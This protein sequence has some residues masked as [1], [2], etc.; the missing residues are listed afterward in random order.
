MVVLHVLPSC[1]CH[2][3]HLTHKC[4][5]PRPSSRARDRLLGTRKKKQNN[6][7]DDDDTFSVKP[8][9]AESAPE[10]RARARCVVRPRTLLYLF[11]PVHAE[12]EHKTRSRAHTNER[13]AA[14]A[15]QTKKKKHRTHARTHAAL[16]GAR[17][18]VCVPEK[19]R[20]CVLE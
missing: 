14:A 2:H 10:S 11:V 3:T 17:V 1:I 7:R 20:A 5:K 19:L 15:Q 8:R 4:G 6:K 16:S 12:F 13:A 18:R 9:A